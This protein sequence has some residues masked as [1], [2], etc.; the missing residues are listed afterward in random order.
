MKSNLLYSQLKNFHFGPLPLTQVGSECS[1]FSPSLATAISFLLFHISSCCGNCCLPRGLATM[2]LPDKAVSSS[3]H[4]FM[5]LSTSALTV[6]PS[7]P[8]FWENRIAPSLP[9]LCPHPTKSH[10]RSLVCH[11][12]QIS[13]LRE[14]WEVTWSSECFLLSRGCEQSH[15]P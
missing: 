14:R 4:W 13:Q 9:T 12:N 5:T 6:F 10:D 7:F 11:C 1:R 3:L 2:A 15:L 8:K